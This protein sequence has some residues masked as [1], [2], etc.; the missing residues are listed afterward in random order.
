MGRRLIASREFATGG[1]EPASTGMKTRTTAIF[2]SIPAFSR[3]TA[4]AFNTIP[5]ELP[6]MTRYPRPATGDGR[7]ASRWRLG[8]L[9]MSTVATGTAVPCVRT[10]H[11][12]EAM[13]R[14]N[15]LRSRPDKAE[16]QTSEV[17]SFDPA[18]DA[19]EIAAE[20][21]TAGYPESESGRP[22]E[23]TAGPDAPPRHGR[24]E[25]ANKSSR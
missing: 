6:S 9:G 7:P 17:A 23:G 4:R 10:P 16:G 21:A 5:V 14:Q 12:G 15:A 1:L 25:R 11:E 2:T 19:T 22:D 8:D 24:P 13:A 20:D 18:S 3:E